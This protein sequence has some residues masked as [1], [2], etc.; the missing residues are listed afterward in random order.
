MNVILFNL[1]Y[2]MQVKTKRRENAF[3][4]LNKLFPK[5]SGYTNYLNEIL[6]IYSGKR[7]TDNK[8]KY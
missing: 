1:P 4:I 6:L 5:T 8:K 3:S 7:E 2:N